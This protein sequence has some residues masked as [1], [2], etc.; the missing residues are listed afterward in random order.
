MNRPASVASPDTRQRILDAAIRCV[1][2]FGIDKTN[3]NDIAREAGVTRPTVYNH[4][5]NRDEVVQAALLQSGYGFAER[6]KTHVQ[7]Y[8]SA[9]ERLV[10]ALMF[11]YRQLPKEPY[12]EL[13]TKGNITQMVN[14]TA[15]TSAEGQAICLEIFASIIAGRPELEADLAEIIELSTRLLLSFLMIE[16]P[17]KRTDKQL[18]DLLTR[19]LL[20]A[21]GMQPA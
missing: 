4:F 16:G 20:P 19:R 9:E 18:R 5:G 13:I 11:A 6:V 2:Q 7:R 1:Q 10:E 17:I 3:M 15:L 8:G 21:L 12:L 14:E